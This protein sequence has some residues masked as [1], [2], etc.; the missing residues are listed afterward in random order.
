MQNAVEEVLQRTSRE[1]IQSRVFKWQR[2]CISDADRISFDERSWQSSRHDKNEDNIPELFLGKWLVNTHWNGNGSGWCNEE[3]SSIPFT[4]N[5]VNYNLL[6]HKSSLHSVNAQNSHNSHAMAR[7]SCLSQTN[8]NVKS[9]S[10]MRSGM[11]CS[12]STAFPIAIESCNMTSTDTKMRPHIRLSH[13]AH[14]LLH[15]LRNVLNEIRF[16]VRVDTSVLQLRVFEITC[17]RTRLKFH[18]NCKT[19]METFV[20]ATKW[21]IVKYKEMPNASSSPGH[22]PILQS[23]WISHNMVKG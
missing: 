5:G 16:V 1:R 6:S 14:F 15:Y 19:D 20:C 12:T 3:P 17:W 7:L 18:A 2:L 21:H 13:S 8:S 11:L 4:W 23:H 9:G 10:R 22:F